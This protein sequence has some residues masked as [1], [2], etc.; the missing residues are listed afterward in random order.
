MPGHAR[1][2]YDLDMSKPRGLSRRQLI[3]GVAPVV[4]AA[5]FA[6]MALAGRREL[7]ATHMGTEHPAMGH[8]AMIGEAAPAPGGPNDLDAVTYP[9][10]ALPHQPGRVREYTLLAQDTEIEVAKGVFYPAWTYN[11]TAPGPVIRATED[12]ILRV[13]FRNGG[14]HPHTIHFHGI[15]PANMDGVF[16]I[17]EPGGSFT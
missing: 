8:A 11:G 17:V 6:G 9:P 13:E 4:A 2:N 3:A 5:P 12:D 1:L 10:A 7:E 14:G 16:E 15:H